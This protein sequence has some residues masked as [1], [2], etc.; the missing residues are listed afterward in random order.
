M[1]SNIQWRNFKKSIYIYSQKEESKERKKKKKS[2][3]TL[4][5]IKEKRK[6]KRN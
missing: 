2:T 1:R 3:P 6:L 4:Q 5:D